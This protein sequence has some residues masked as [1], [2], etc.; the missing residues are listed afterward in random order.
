[1][2]VCTRCVLPETY[3]G[4]TFDE[5]GVCNHCRKAE[6]FA[7]TAEQRVEYQ[8]KLAALL[9]QY[10][11]R[12]HQ[13]LMAYSGGKDSTY[14]MALMKKKYGAKIIAFTFDNG[15]IST[16][17]MTNIAMVCS[18]L[19]IEHIMVRYDQAMLDELFR[20]GAENDMYGMKTMTRAST[21]CTICSGFFKS[22]ALMTAL[23][24]DIPFIGYGW[25]P[26]QAPIQSA[27]SQANPKFVKAAQGA[28]RGPVEKVCGDKFDFDEYFLKPHH[29]A[30]AEEKWPFNV[31]PLAFEDYDEEQIKQDIRAL[32]WV[33]PSDVD[34][35]STNCTMN[36]FANEVHIQRYGFHPYAQEIANMVRQGTMSREEGMEKIYT[37]QNPELV[38]FALEKIGLRVDS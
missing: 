16:Q 33:D 9:G 2:K 35:N 24:R 3:P 38:N 7:S 31:N 11:D 15:F 8:E 5:E 12:E 32:G 28:A 21:I 19:D 37:D 4:I 22:V 13:M 17:A 34:S 26:G 18:K 36:A 6:S 1:M 20:H 25:S 23:D 14:T 27:L 30:V 29:Y 10:E